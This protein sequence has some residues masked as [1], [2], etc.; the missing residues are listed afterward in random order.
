MLAF[1]IVSEEEVFAWTPR[2]T[3]GKFTDLIVVREGNNDVV[4]VTVERFINGRWSK[5]IERKDLRQ[6]RNVEDAW[7]VDCGLALEGAAQSGSVTVYR[8]ED[9]EYTAVRTAGSFTGTENRVLRVANGIFRV[10]TVTSSTEVALTARAEPDNW[11]PQTDRAFTYPESDWTLDTPVTT[12]SGLSHLEGEEVVILGDGNV[13]PRQTVVNGAITLPNAVTR[14]IAGLPYK[15]RAKTLPLIIPD[16]GIEA[17]RKRIVAVSPRLINSRGLKIGHSYDKLYEMKERT[18]EMWGV[19]IAL[20]DGV[21][22]ESIGTT[23]DEEAFTYFELDDPLPVTL[24]SL[25][26]DTEVGDEPD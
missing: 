4:Y 14:A 5:F 25:V 13:M 10:D 1:T 11:V 22:H 24:L 16:A 17:K 2:D 12:L 18:T 7:C 15:C 8:S 26:Q 23:W 20:Q 3:K 9:D 21:H 6:F 19:P